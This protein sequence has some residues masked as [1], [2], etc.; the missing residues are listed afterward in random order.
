M[1]IECC[2]APVHACPP[3]DPARSLGNCDGL[4]P[5]ARRV[6]PMCC[7]QPL[8]FTRCVFSK[9]GELPDRWRVPQEGD[10]RSWRRQGKPVHSRHRMAGPT[11]RCVACEN[12]NGL[13]AVIAAIQLIETDGEIAAGEPGRVK[14]PRR[15]SGA[16]VATV[17]NTVVLGEATE[18]AAVG[19]ARA[20]ALVRAP[21]HGTVREPVD[22][23]ADAG[24]ASERGKVRDVL[25]A[26][27]QREAASALAPL[28]R[29]AIATVRLSGSG[30]ERS[31]P[32]G[33]RQRAARGT[34]AEARGIAAVSTRS[35]NRSGEPG[36]EATRPNP[37]SCGRHDGRA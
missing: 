18:A 23:E 26:E 28:G 8:E 16:E 10:G 32:L 14:P 22:G 19:P 12:L 25:G 33:K 27:R 17:P 29:S 4:R 7:A 30:G 36:R 11:A 13:Q 34:R 15:L 6:T 9:H 21:L 5:R 3:W 20:S 2:H 1:P 37:S 35:G 31:E 24:D